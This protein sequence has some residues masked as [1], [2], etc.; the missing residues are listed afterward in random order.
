MLSSGDTSVNRDEEPRSDTTAGGH[1]GDN[2]VG[3]ATCGLVLKSHRVIAGGLIRHDL[4][5]PREG[6]ASA[7]R[8]GQQTRK[9]LDGLDVRRL[10]SLV[11][12]L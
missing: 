5:V 7:N 6:P 3:E 4:L 1:N 11:T 8:H 12:G 10:W 2:D 9:A